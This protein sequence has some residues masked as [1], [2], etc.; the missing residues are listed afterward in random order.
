MLA[1]LSEFVMVDLSFVAPALDRLAMLPELPADYKSMSR[2]VRARVREEYARRQGGICPFCLQP[3]T[4]D[5]PPCVTRLPLSK[6][7][8]PPEFFRWPVHLHHDHRTGLTIGAY[9]ARCNAVLACYL[10]E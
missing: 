10:H 5:P 4:G 3:L 7:L 6:M 8:W 9:H 1:G 2:E